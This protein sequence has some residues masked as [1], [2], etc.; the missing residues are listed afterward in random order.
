M[1]CLY[2]L[3]FENDYLQY[4]APIST[5]VT[6]ACSFIQKY[7]ENISAIRKL[8]ASFSIGALRRAQRPCPDLLPCAMSALF[9]L[10]AEPDP[11]VYVTAYN[12][13][14]GLFVALAPFRAWELVQAYISVVPEFGVR[15][16]MPGTTAVALISLFVFLAQHVPAHKLVKFVARTPIL[17]CFETDVRQFIPFVPQLVRQLTHVEPLFHKNLMRT[18]VCASENDPAPPFI[19]ALN[20]MFDAYPEILRDFTGMMC[21]KLWNNVRFAVGPHILQSDAVCC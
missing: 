2:T 3:L 13:I 8:R 1:R 6:S 4:A 14:G 20:S 12:A 17:P 19:E 18:L 15:E 11:T 5:V 21:S 9:Q 7:I 10:T 16:S